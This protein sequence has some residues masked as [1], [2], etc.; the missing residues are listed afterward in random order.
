MSFLVA[1]NVVASRPPK[2]RPT[3]MPHACAKKKE[4]KIMLFLVATNV[5]ASRPPERRPTR[6]PHARANCWTNIVVGDKTGLELACASDG[7]LAMMLVAEFFCSQL[8]TDNGVSNQGSYPAKVVQS[9][10]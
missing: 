5:I 8:V 4:K 3:G 1:T 6:T 2:R 9:D 7:W 10:Q